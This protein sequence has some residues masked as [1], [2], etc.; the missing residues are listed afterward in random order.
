MARKSFFQNTKKA[1]GPQVQPKTT[2]MQTSLSQQ[3]LLKKVRYI[4]GLTNYCV[5][6]NN[7]LKQIEQGLIE[8]ISADNYKQYQADIQAI[9]NEIKQL[10]ADIQA[11]DNEAIA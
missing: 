5:S 8:P 6:V 3:H 1:I 7:Q 4:G 11:V 9:Y 2:S 10:Q